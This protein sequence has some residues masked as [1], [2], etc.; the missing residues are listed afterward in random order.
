M[1]RKKPQKTTDRIKVI[2][3]FNL[4][5]YFMTEVKIKSEAEFHDNRIVNEKEKRLGFAYKSVDDVFR[6]PL[7]YSIEATADILEIGCFD[8]AQANALKHKSFNS[9][10]G[11]DISPKAIEFCKS[12]ISDPRINFLV[13]NAESL[14]NL[15]GNS[16]SYAFGNGVLHHLNLEKFSEALQRVLKHGGV[17]RF[18]EPAQGPW[19][20]RLFRK[21]TPSLRTK[22][23]YPFDE[24]SINTLRRYFKVEVSRCGY[25]RPWVPIIFANTKLATK[26][27]CWIDE[28]CASQKVLDKQAWLLKI[29]LRKL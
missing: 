5:A 10:V 3:N 15:A 16:I 24:S 29:E 9:Y 28:K 21:I 8:G 2:Q 17:A 12:K 7:Q 19:I 1:V 25:A 6:Y 11:I 27:S 13:E 22:D 26:V 18:V 23:E 14:D 4:K 20:L